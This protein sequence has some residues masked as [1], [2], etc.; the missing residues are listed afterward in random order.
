MICP[1]KLEQI[2]IQVIATRQAPEALGP[3]SQAVVHAGLVY[4]S[5][6]IPIDPKT[7][8]LFSG[9]ITEQTRLIL[10]N[11]ASILAEAGTELNNALKVTVYLT[12]MNNFAEMNAE[13]AQHFS[14][15]KPARAC[16]QVARL[17]KD[18][19][20]EIDAIAAI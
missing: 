16:V 5:G 2:M 11:I 10:N 9:S 18:V 12:D 13:Y 8:Q 6:Q 4:V 3:Y 20:I 7:G 19:T 14:R 1:A 17:P 15:N